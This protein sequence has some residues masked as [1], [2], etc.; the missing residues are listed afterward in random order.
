MAG[1]IISAVAL[2]YVFRDQDPVALLL[3][4]RRAH[5]FPFVS[6]TVLVTAVFWIRAWRWK[7]LLKT[8][9]PNTAF[10][11]RFGA[12]T[13]RFMANNVFPSGRVG[14]IAGP[15]ALAKI[16]RL[17]FV[18]SMTSIVL[19]RVLDALTG[20]FLFLLSLNLPGVPDLVGS[21]AF[22]ARAQQIG[23]VMLLALTI[24]IASVVWPDSTTAFAN[25]IASQMPRRIG[26]WLRQAA[27]A[28]I[29]TARA[30]RSWRVVVRAV[31]WSLV[32]W[33]TNAAGFWLAMRAFN[34]DYS[35]AAVLF[36][37]GVLVVVVSVPSAPGFFGVYE[38]AA[39]LVLVN[40]W[41]ADASTTNAFAASYHIA[42]YIPV[43]AI[44]LYYAR[45]FGVQ[46]YQAAKTQEAAAS[47]GAGA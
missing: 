12:T 37:Q 2:Y 20:V 31:G 38:F 24:P 27:E 43:T 39:A 14:E 15:W 23:V 17:P 40:M 25:K 33:L 26:P 5:P 35:F 32:L 47:S 42:G 22:T 30:L 19:E 6:A 34:L 9:Q 16:E 18:S 10:R 7:A 13:I 3:A 45:A 1:F 29:V 4:V 28:F 36:F 46:S 11:S 21:E 41:G 44:G 8:V